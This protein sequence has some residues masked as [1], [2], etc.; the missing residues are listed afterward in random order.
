MS[1]VEHSVTTGRGPESEHHRSGVPFG[2]QAAAGWSWRI[3]VV[4]AAIYLLFK[5]LG[6]FELLVVPVLVA[7][8][9]GAGLR[10]LVDLTARRNGRPG[11]PRGVAA[12]LTVVL[13]LV[14][15]AGL[16]T[17][18][19][20]QVTTGFP[21][22]AEQ[23]QGGY[24]RLQRDLAAGPLHLTDNQITT[25]INNGLTAV[26]ANSD[27]LVTGAVKVGATVTDIGSGFFIALFSTFF[28]L[29]QGDA[30]WAW[31]VRLFPRDARSRVDGAGVRAWATLTA[32]VRA[33]VIV[34]AVD[35]LGVG[36]VAFGLGVPL[37]APLGVLVFLGA[38]VPIIGSLVSGSVA[39]LV[40]L[41]ALG[42]LKALLM[43]AGVIAVQQ[44]ESHVLQPFLMGHAVRVHPLAVILAIG[45]G[46]LTA[47]VVGA[48]FAVPLAAVINVVGSYLA[49]TESASDPVRDVPPDDG[50]P[51][52]EEESW[53]EPGEEEAVEREAGPLAD[54]PEDRG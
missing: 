38:F 32:Y 51:S 23:A 21:S 49:G 5:A 3:L 37:A 19:G 44:L 46:V 9:V 54:R 7:M 8:L 53:R 16:F 39:V 40:A 2:L 15:V 41:V 28:F 42:P 43:L 6:M 11:L 17:L 18:V 20:Q 10:P 27:R 12:G 52:A 22:L 1:P 29:Y 34:A 4:G 45:A 47:G 50:E 30:I 14:L 26:R 13:T 36:L 24:L 25:W 35:G 31:L 48:L 33:T